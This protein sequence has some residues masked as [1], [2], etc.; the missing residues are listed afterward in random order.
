MRTGLPVRFYKKLTH[1][2]MPKQLAFFKGSK[3]EFDT[4]QNIIELESIGNQLVQDVLDDIK[5]Y[6]EP[7]VKRR[8]PADDPLI[9]DPIQDLE[10]ELAF[11]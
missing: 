5:S 4:L 10:L 11:V 7:Q 3:R 6:D 2:D 9:I 8:K 1:I